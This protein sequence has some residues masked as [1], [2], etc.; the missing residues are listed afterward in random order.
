[1]RATARFAFIGRFVRNQMAFVLL[2]FLVLLAS[3]VSPVFLVPRNIINLVRGGSIVGIVAMGQTLLLITGHFDMSVSSVA[4][5]AGIVTVGLQ[6]NGYGLLPSI[7]LGLLSGLVVGVLNAFLIV[8]T[9]ANPFLITLGS[10]TF[11]YAIALILTGAKTWYATIPAFNVIGRGEL[12]G[13]LP[14]PVILLLILALL[15]EGLLRLTIVGRYLYAIGQNA[16]AARLSG[17]PVDKVRVG[18]YVFCGF[19]AALAGIVLTSRLN[20]TVANAGVGLDFDSIIATVLGGTS[21]F[22]GSGGVLRTI[23]G[24][25]VV[26]VLGNLL[27]LLNV[28]YEAQQLVRGAVF[29]LVVWFDTLMKRR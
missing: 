5:F 19:T 1:M 18:A 17:V 7:A 16:E 22:G 21:L 15:L 3:L 8:K 27:I 2:V 24:V 28:P 29:V 4:A 13:I 26:N 10:Q 14:Y 9:K 25:L 12:W 23:V 6:I 20:S 11:V